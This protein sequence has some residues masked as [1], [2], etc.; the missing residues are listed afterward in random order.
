MFQEPFLGRGVPDDG[1]PRRVRTAL[2]ALLEPTD[3]PP[4]FAPGLLGLVPETRL[5]ARLADQ[6]AFACAELRRDP[7]GVAAALTAPDFADTRSPRQMRALQSALLAAGAAFA[8]V[9]VHTVAPPPRDD[10]SVLE[11]AITRLARLAPVGYGGGGSGDRDPAPPTRGVRPQSSLADPIA[12]A[13][14]KPIVTQPNP[15][16]IPAPVKAP[17]LPPS[18]VQMGTFGDPLGAIGD[19]SNGPG[20]G[21]G[22]GT[23]GGGGFGPGV[24]LGE[25]PGLHDGR[26]GGLP[27]D[28]AS[29][30]S[31]VAVPPVVLNSPRP[32]Y[33]E[34]ARQKK[35]QGEVF[36][37]VLFGS[38]GRVREARVLRGLPDGLNERAL[39]AVYRF[40]FRPARNAAGAPLDA[41]MTVKV[42]FTIR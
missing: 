39:E 29:A 38:N 16:P 20:G 6:L 18:L 36:V 13:T 24:G 22:I 4:D 8:L 5:T 42:R 30:T 27:D 26:L 11:P 25:G 2:V 12:P 14:A 31:R 34:E 19:S 33:T 10:P 9:A 28:D 32:E 15:L 41:W 7:F 17:P 23:G 40:D 35:T 3:L 1:W 21:G 37:R